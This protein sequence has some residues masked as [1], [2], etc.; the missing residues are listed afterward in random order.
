[1]E[2]RRCRTANIALQAL[3]GK[4]RQVSR[5]VPKLGQSAANRRPVANPTHHSRNF[6]ISSRLLEGDGLGPESRY[7]RCK[8]KLHLMSGFRV[9]QDLRALVVY[10]KK[11]CR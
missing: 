9:S 4:G 10:A 11:S 3:V 8:V 5:L 1:M 7:R 2:R 6:K